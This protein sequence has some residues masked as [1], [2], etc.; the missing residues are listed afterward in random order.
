MLRPLSFAAA[1]GGATLL[2][3]AGLHASESRFA[4]ASAPVPA[5]AHADEHDPAQV[6]FA[7]EIRPLLERSCIGCHGPE[8]QKH[9]F[10]VDRKED[11]FRGGKACDE[12]GEKGIVP[13]KPE[14]SRLYW[15]IT[16]TEEDEDREIFPMPPTESKAQRLTKAEV[17]RI[18]A[19]IEQGAAWPEGL[20]LGG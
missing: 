7:R 11:A 17:A 5:V 18:R 2:A 20:V 19:W 12:F 9:D 8:K 14:E 10:R 1:C 13:G 3:L 4:P 6:D 15:M 16:A